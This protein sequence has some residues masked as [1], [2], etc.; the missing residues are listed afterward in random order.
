[1]SPRVLVTGGAGF[2]GSHLTDSLLSSGVDVVVLDDLSTGSS[3]NLAAAQMQP[4][5]RMVQGSVLDQVLVDELVGASDVVFHLAAAVGV[6]LIMNRPLDSFLVNIHGTYNVMEAAQQHGTR[7]IL[8]STSEVF[9]RNTDVPLHDD[10]HRVLGSP[11]VTRWWYALS[12]GVDEVLAVGYQRERGVPTSV[13]RFFN[14]VGPRQVDH[15]GMVIPRFVGQAMRDEPITIYG[16]GSQSRTFCHVA[17]TVDALLRMFRSIDTVGQTFN[18]GGTREITIRQ[19]AELVVAT[20]DSRSTLVTV[21]YDEV[22]PDGFED[23]ARRLPDTSHIQ[24][25]TGWQPTR[26]LEQI[27]LDVRDHVLATQ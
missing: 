24:A 2:I 17:D 13:A 16:D 8:A 10:S 11:E 20:L 27:I 6:Q 1:V 4:G 14:T 12:K 3:A 15:Y 26:S 23:L 22:F 9:G 19:L 21:P 5:F 7:V 25:A 18:I